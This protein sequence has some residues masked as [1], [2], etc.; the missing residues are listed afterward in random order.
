MAAHL[1]LERLDEPGVRVEQPVEAVGRG[2]GP[3]RRESLYEV[4]CCCGDANSSSL[5][6]AIDSAT[7]A[8][9]TSMT[10]EPTT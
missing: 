3:R 10:A 1:A 5:M 7:A 2:V 4:G 9:A 8:P 6:R